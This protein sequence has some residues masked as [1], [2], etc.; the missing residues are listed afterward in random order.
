MSVLKRR[1]SIIKIAPILVPED[2]YSCKKENIPLFI[3][4]LKFEI[5]SFIPAISEVKWILNQSKRRLADYLK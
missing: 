5:E 2:S 1:F 3:L 4:S